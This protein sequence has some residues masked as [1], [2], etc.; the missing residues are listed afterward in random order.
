AFTYGRRLDEVRFR[1]GRRGDHRLRRRL[2]RR[3]PHG[4]LRGQE[5]PRRPRRRRPLRGAHGRTD[6]QRPRPRTPVRLHPHPRPGE[7]PGAR[8]RR[9]SRADHAPRTAHRL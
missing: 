5:H 3:Y 9:A 8:D 7:V 2:L 1:S 6:R 4:P